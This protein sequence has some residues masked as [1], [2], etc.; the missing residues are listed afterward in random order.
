MA[1]NTWTVAD[2]TNNP[3]QWVKPNSNPDAAPQYVKCPSVYNFEIDDISKPDAGRAANGRMY[4]S[5]LYRGANPV[6]AFAI[7]LEWQNITDAD[8]AGLLAI[9]Q[10]EEYLSVR[11]FNPVSATYYTAPFYVGNRTM[12]MYNKA[13]KIWSGLSLKLISR[14]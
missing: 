11:Y 3:I 12:P 6:R 1:V 7:S 14:N 13:M 9:F 10:Q 5:Q 8:V 2:A 4:K